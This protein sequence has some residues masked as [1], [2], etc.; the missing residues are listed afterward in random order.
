MSRDPRSRLLAVVPARGG[1]RRVPRKNV[2]MLQGRPALAYTVD[3]AL[4]S[5]LFARVVV[6]TDDPEIAMIAEACG[7]EVPFLRPPALADDVTPVSAATADALDRLDPDGTRFDAVAQLMASCPLRVAADVRASHAAF[8]ASGAGAQL[9]VAPFAVQTPWW[10]MRRA[11]D[12]TLAPLFPDMVVQRSQDLP[13]LVCPT[14]AVWWARADVLRRARTFH[15]PGR[16]GWALP[17]D[18]ALDIDTE[19]DWRMASRLLAGAQREAPATLAT[20]G[21]GGSDAS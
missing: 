7:A 17:W 6:S 15:V 18:R 8:V 11:E 19:E 14:G 20:V 13:P 21:P 1:S 5:G 10:A 16:T 2:R 12:G 4:D 9:S 3:A